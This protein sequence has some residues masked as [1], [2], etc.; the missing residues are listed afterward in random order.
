MSQ[1]HVQL[2]RMLT[3]EKRLDSLTDIHS[4][5]LTLPKRLKSLDLYDVQSIE[6][7]LERLHQQWVSLK[8]MLIASVRVRA[9]PLLK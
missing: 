6:V 2:E 5:V 1:I 9:N 3:V 4:T 7:D 8:V